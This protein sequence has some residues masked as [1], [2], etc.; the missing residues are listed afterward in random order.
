MGG[1]PAGED[2]QGRAG[3]GRRRERGGRE[4]SEEQPVQ[5]L[6]P[7]VLGELLPTPG[8]SGGNTKTAWWRGPDFR[9]TDRRGQGSPDGGRAETGGEGRTDLPSGLLRLPTR[10]PR[11]GRG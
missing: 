5:D 11:P 7:D 8:E 9:R 10:A 1:I 2:Q 4:G 6:E 3:R